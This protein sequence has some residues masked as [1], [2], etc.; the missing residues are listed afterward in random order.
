MLQHVP[1]VIGTSQKPR[2]FKNVRAFPADYSFS[3]NAWTTNGIWSDWLRKWDGSLCFQQQKIALLVD[4]CC[5]HGDVEEL[6]CI[7][8]VKLPPNPTLQIQLCDMGIIR[9]LKAYCRHKI[10]ARIIDAIED[11][12]NDSSINAGTIAKRL[13]VLDV[14]HI[15]A[16]SWNK[17][18]KETIRNFWRKDNF[19]CSRVTG[20]RVRDAHSGS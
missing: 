2:C 17:V 11:G 5:A 4:N 6:K 12:C 19:F 7:E 1:L 9:T 10:R 3:K 16:S 8:V 15:L 13:S 20:A 14:L 18:T